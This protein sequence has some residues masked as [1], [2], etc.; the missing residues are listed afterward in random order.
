MSCLCLQCLQCKESDSLTQEEKY[1]KLLDK[2]LLKIVSGYKLADLKFIR[3]ENDIPYCL[4][5]L[6]LIDNQ[7]QTL[8]EC[9]YCHYYVGHHAC[10]RKAREQGN[11]LCKACG[12][13][14]FQ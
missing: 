1:K 14:L 5:C 10:F 9:D 8:I 3:N 7:K 12:N 2:E 4:Y 11:R 6:K 13:V